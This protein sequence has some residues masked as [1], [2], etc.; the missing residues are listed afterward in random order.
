MI[1]LLKSK[2]TKKAAILFLAASTVYPSQAY[3]VNVTKLATPAID[4]AS[5]GT[6]VRSVP[7]EHAPTTAP[8]KDL[9]KTLEK[10]L[11]KG[12]KGDSTDEKDE[13]KDVVAIPAP[14][15]GKAISPS[16]VAV[17]KDS[18]TVEIHVNDANLIEVLR[19]LSMQSN[20]NILPSKEVRGTITANLY[21]VTVKEALDAILQANG[22]GY[23]EKGN[24][25]YVMS[26][27]EIADE[28]K[29]SHKLVTR[30]F[31]LYYTPAINAQT[32][33][34]PVLSSE[35]QVAVTT[36][37]ISG[38]DSSSKETG[39]NTHA[40]EDMM[41][42]TDYQENID[43]IEKIL[44]D[45]DKRPQQ[46]L[47][48]ATILRAA[49]SED[50]ALG[51]DFTLLGGVN[52]NAL[53]GAGSSTGEA[54]SGNIVNNPTASKLAS[55]GMS[56][57]GTGFTAGV[58]AGGLRAG[59][60]TNNVAVFLSALEEVT[61]TVVMANPKIL[62]LNKQKGEVKVA[63]QD[64][65]RGKTTTSAT[66]IIQQEVDFLETGTLLIIRPYIGDDGFIR[67]EVHPE[68][69]T[70]LPSRAADLP[71]T[72]LTTEST[73]NIMVKDG[74][75][76]VIGGLFRETSQTS[77]SQIPGIGNIPWIGNLFRNQKDTTQ[78]EEVI[79]L[80]TPHLIKDDSMYSRQSEAQLKEAEKMRVGVRTGM[81]FFGRERLAECSYEQAVAEWN[82]PNPNRQKVLWHLNC[83]TNLNP[84]F[85]EA[86]DLKQ[87]VS[88]KEV[89]AVDNS[90]IRTFVRQQILLDPPLPPVVM[91][92]TTLPT[93]LPV[94]IAPATQ[95][96][97][98]IIAAPT[99]Q[100]LAIAP[101]T[102]PSVPAPQASIN[103]PLQIDPDESFNTDEVES[104]LV[105]SPSATAASRSELKIQSTVGI[106]DLLDDGLKE[107]HE[108][109]DK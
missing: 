71:P 16:D 54:L 72:K 60:I 58:P 75:T 101:T 62:M 14:S 1:R 32:M 82:K 104:T 70:P 89:T 56:A 67:M 77:R 23:R 93:T 20:T 35:G 38:I 109:S 5:N 12:A 92:P 100:P 98:A 25:I 2:W 64:P 66:G 4:G 97:V 8:S 43:R 73:T 57:V 13:P 83:A 21:D 47:V 36:P 11:A 84:T 34:K 27:K 29:N 74:H 37:A 30:V 41:V 59:V 49:L 48:E 10:I 68:D 46:I 28:N 40:V 85:L 15:A 86:I 107:L 17:S 90:S 106:R 91:A 53:T 52:F 45:I 99:T 87:K 94:A 19:M 103:E 76:I 79:I 39:G 61:N 78:R 63:R 51:I 42:V 96:A 55:N 6:E 3:A 24:V 22:Y 9:A 95:P 7:D 33:I 44:K 105:N 26:A 102:Q 18:G 81:M 50:N 69:S 108:K 65:F 80:L 88:G 31:H